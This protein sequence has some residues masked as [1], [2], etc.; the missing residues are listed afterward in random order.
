MSP[1]ASQDKFQSK[2]ISVD[3]QAI[4]V[5]WVGV[6]KK[7][8]FQTM[9]TA[10]DCLSRLADKKSVYVNLETVVG[11]DSWG[12]GS[13][14]RLKNKLR[15]RGRQLLLGSHELLLHRRGLGGIDDERPHDR[16]RHLRP[17]K[18][19]LWISSR[20]SVGSCPHGQLDG[21]VSARFGG[22]K[23]GRFRKP[24]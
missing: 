10:E 6:V 8:S 19:R 3:E 16:E 15:P 17:S 4:R 7:E 24:G 23:R 20:K 2:I 12:I 21:D 11:I 13:L 22:R 14:L 5:Q 1:F 9:S 18:C